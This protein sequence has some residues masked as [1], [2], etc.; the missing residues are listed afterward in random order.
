[1][2]FGVAF[3]G[4]CGIASLGVLQALE[5]MEMKA[6]ALYLNDNSILP[7]CLWAAGMK[8]ERI[9]ERCRKIRK[10]PAGRNR[11]FRAIQS[12]IGRFTPKIKI[13]LSGKSCDYTTEKSLFPE[14]RSLLDS[15][16]AVPEMVE[17]YR[18]AGRPAETRPQTW[19]LTGMG[20]ERILLVSPDCCKVEDKCNLHIRLPAYDR[21]A[22]EDLRI[23][24]YQGY[25]AT[26]SMQKKI[27]ERLLF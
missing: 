24:D 13:Y 12:E 17:G 23:S 20:C 18:E 9:I 2:K 22:M 10:R 3:S 1:M 21:G 5:E 19:P 8:K 6:E 11:S 27:Y 4:V 26:L 14:V 7:V 25:R 15:R 16:A